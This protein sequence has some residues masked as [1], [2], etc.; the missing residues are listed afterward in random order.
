MFNLTQA[1]LLVIGAWVL[2]LSWVILQILK[3]YKQKSE[4]PSRVNVVKMRDIV[5]IRPTRSAG[6]HTTPR[7]KKA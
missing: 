5:R 1:E 2:V 7:R 3:E 6:V 4:K